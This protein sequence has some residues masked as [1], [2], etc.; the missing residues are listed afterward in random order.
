MILKTLALKGP[1]I[2][3][4]LFKAIGS[5]KEIAYPTI[6]RRVDDL[7][8]RGYLQTAGTRTIIVGKREDESST[9]GLTWKGVIASLTIESVA[10]S[11]L[12]VLEKNPYLDLPFPREGP[13]RIVRELF[14]DE[15]LRSIGQAFLT[16]YLTA[17]PRD[18]ESLKPE[19]LIVYAFPAMSEMPQI[20]DKIGEK[21]LSGLMQIPE[22][23]SF[24][25][26][27]LRDTEKTLEQ[28]LFGIK[29]MRKALDEYHRG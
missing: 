14:T 13:L 24:F 17:I 10:R 23:Y 4:D 18:L 25:S 15:E 9:Y 21:D 2:K 27:M 28:T 19:Q 11:I 8:D 7:V 26:K 1:L 6:S 16:G 20:Q 29:E 5:L 22:V 3:Y 12:T